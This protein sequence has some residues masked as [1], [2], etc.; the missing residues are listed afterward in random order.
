MEKHCKG[1][2]DYQ[3]RDYK[4]FLKHHKEFSP[5]KIIDISKKKRELSIQ[6]E[7]TKFK[8][9]KRA[10]SF[11]EWINSKKESSTD[12]VKNF[13]K[14]VGKRNTRALLSLFDKLGVKED[15]GVREMLLEKLEGY[16]V[17]DAG[18]RI[19]ILL[20]SEFNNGKCVFS[21]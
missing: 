15:N 19:C 5:N 6:K 13:S 17:E 16:N 14:N 10:K 11:M 9:E 7:F 18:P 1:V 4:G 3:I 2:S 20:S 21:R 12:S 8:L